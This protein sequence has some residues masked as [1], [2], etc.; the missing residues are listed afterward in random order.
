ME[1]SRAGG[2]LSVVFHTEIKVID[3]GIVVLELTHT[4]YH[5]MSLHK[6]VAKFFFLLINNL[7]R[8]YFTVKKTMKQLI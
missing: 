1:Q 8:K 7:V 6:M 3:Y 5:T 4:A 2:I